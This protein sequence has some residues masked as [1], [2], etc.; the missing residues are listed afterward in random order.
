MLGNGCGVGAHISSHWVSL[1]NAEVAAENQ[2]YFRVTSC[3]SSLVD[4]ANKPVVAQRNGAMRDVYAGKHPLP[5]S[6]AQVYPFIQL[7]KQFM[8]CF[9]VLLASVRPVMRL[10]SIEGP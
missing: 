5:A 10:P 9:H 4:C 2:C 3:M 8:L 1:F 6:D 7:T